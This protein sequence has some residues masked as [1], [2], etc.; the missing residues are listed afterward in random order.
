[1]DHIFSIGQV[2]RMLKV[3]PYRIAYA[4]ETGQLPDAAFHFLH[5]RCFT[6]AD[7]QRIAQFFGV[8]MNIELEIEKGGK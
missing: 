8:E 5:K 6:E 1:M 2:G 3:Q 4:I 7:I